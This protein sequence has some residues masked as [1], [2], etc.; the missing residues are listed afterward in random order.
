MGLLCAAITPTLL[1]LHFNYSASFWIYSLIFMLFAG[2]S[3][4][5]LSRIFAV[6]A[7]SKRQSKQTKDFKISRYFGGNRN[8]FYTIYAIS[9]IASSIPAVLVLF[10]I[11]SQLQAEEWTGLFLLIYFIAGIAGLPIW[12]R[13]TLRYGK[14]QTW[15]MSMAVAVLSFVWAYNLESGD[16][17]AYG[18]ICFAS[19]VAL[20]AELALPPSILSD[21][22]DAESNPTDTSGHFAVMHFFLKLSLALASFIGLTYLDSADFN[23]TSTGT[24]IALSVSYAMFPSLIKLTALALAGVWLIQLNGDK[25]H[26]FIYGTHSHRRNNHA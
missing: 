21:L 17:I 5:L 18:L 13:I 12:Q 8:M 3:L 20:G 10:F 26:A 14:L 6:T 23:P 1:Q 19:G 24:S 11:R 25:K 9:M 15:M 2:L 22:I 4:L 7:N 16:L